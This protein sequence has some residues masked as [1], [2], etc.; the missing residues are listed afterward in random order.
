[1]SGVG[2][3]IIGAYLDLLMPKQK[4]LVRAR[5]KSTTLAGALKEAGVIDS[6]YRRWLLK[7]AFAAVWEVVT[8]EEDAGAE[9]LLR[10]RMVGVVAEAMGKVEAYLKMPLDGQGGVQRPNIAKARL[11]QAEFG[12]KVVL[13][14]GK[15]KIRKGKDAG[16]GGSGRRPKAEEAAKEAEDEVRDLTRHALSGSK[17]RATDG[18]GGDDAES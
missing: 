6:T 17:G 1:M 2:E 18:K 3:E 12:L 4:A 14:L 5:L 16:S 8:K 13:A 15:E 10:Q 11:E 9:L 7:P